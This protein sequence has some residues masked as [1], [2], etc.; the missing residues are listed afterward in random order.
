[1]AEQDLLP[2]YRAQSNEAQPWLPAKGCS[3][4]AL[5]QEDIFEGF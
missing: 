2:S 5:L 4:P 1:M 3:H